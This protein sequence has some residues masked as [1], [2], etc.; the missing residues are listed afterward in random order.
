MKL[1]STVNTIYVVESGEVTALFEQP[2]IASFYGACRQNGFL[3]TAFSGD[4]VLCRIL[5]VNFS[6]IENCINGH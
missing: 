1:W 2:R 3:Y 5:K 6:K 4:T